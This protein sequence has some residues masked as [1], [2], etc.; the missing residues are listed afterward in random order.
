MSVDLDSELILIAATVK[1]T[2]IFWKGLCLFLTISFW[3]FISSQKVSRCS[4]YGVKAAPTP[5]ETLDYKFYKFDVLFYFYFYLTL[6]SKSMCDVS[7]LSKSLTCI[8]PLKIRPSFSGKFMSKL[9][10]FYLSSPTAYWARFSLK[11]PMLDH[12]EPFFYLI[13]ILHHFY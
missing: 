6:R 11:L 3:E 4:F 13:I 2:R 8:L 1:T 9:C 10:C 7:F 12:L 5:R